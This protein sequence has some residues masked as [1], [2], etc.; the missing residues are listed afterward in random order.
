[1]RKLADE[2]YV[3]AGGIAF[4]SQTRGDLHNMCT[5]IVQTYDVHAQAL[6]KVRI[7]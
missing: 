2:R 4:S 7:R 3:V 1:M 6:H 5:A